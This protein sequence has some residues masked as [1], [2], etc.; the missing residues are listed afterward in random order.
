IPAEAGTQGFQGCARC[1]Q[2]NANALGSRLR[3]N[4]ENLMARCSREFGEEPFFLARR[5]GPASPGSIF[6]P[7]PGSA[8]GTR[9]AYGDARHEA[10]LARVVRD[11]A[12]HGAAVVPHQDLVLAPARAAGE[13]EAGAVLVQVRD[14]GRALL[15]G[16]AF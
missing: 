2:F 6:L 11:G 4:D 5:P 7:V 16:E 8:S 13:V 15:V 12:M 1:A 10:A 14:D 3:G 9:P